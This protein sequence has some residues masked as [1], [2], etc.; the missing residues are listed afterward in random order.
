MNWPGA[1]NDPFYM[2]N[3][4]EN[5]ARQSYY[6]ITD[7]FNM[8]CDGIL[9][10]SGSSY[11]SYFN[12]RTNVVSP[13]DIQMD[14]TVGSQI[15]VTAE[16][17]AESNYTGTNLMFRASLNSVEYTIPGSGWTYTHCMDAMLDLQPSSSGQLFSINPG[18]TVTLNVSFPIPTY[19]PTGLDNLQV[20]GF[21][22]QDSNR[23]VLQARQAGIPLDFPSL[24]LTNY[25]LSDPAPGGNNNGFMEPGETFE[26]WVELSNGEVFAN[27]QNVSAVISTDDPDITVIDGEADFPDILS[28]ASEN[29]SDNPF[30]IEIGENL[31]PHVVTFQIDITA[32][33][34]YTNTEFFQYM[35]GIPEYLIVDDDGGN[36]YEDAYLSYFDDMDLVYNYCNVNEQGP[37]TGATIT[38]YDKVI[39]FT[40]ASATTLD[41][42]EQM[43]LELYLDGGGKLFL[44]SQNLGDEIGG[45]EF[46]TNYM[47]AQADLNYLQV[48]SLDGVPGDPI[49][50]G[51]LILLVGGAFTPTS[52]SSIIPDT[53]AF[54]IYKYTDEDQ[55]CGA[56][57]Y[58]DGYVLVYMAFPWESISPIASGFTH[59]ADVMTSVLAWMDNPLSV[60]PG[61]TVS[62]N[63]P[64]SFEITS[65]SPNPF[66]PETSIRLSVPVSGNIDMVVFNLLGEK[67]A[68]IHE[69]YVSAGNHDF[70]FNGGNL[71]S[72]IYLLKVNTSEGV[73]TEKLVLMK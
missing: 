2:N 69:G 49:T 53:E 20:V 43:V 29:N 44:S 73:L 23:E 36:T 28:G 8:K 16:I 65:I 6:G 34:N 72:G 25:D 11:Q 30:I 38:H 24:T 66:N 42:F 21:V 15:E 63:V 12:Q 33:G 50:E 18:E 1:G 9:G 59:R 52:Q 3:P 41:A 55:S 13:V 67:V 57:R 47:H 46:Y 51:N 5:T 58:T 26:T 56:L 48:L 40:S 45:T 60:D 64:S 35:M 22:Q 17:T 10:N 37:P 14:I 71:S 27:A 68:L 70:T 19:P 4:T 7:V 39:W 31:L 54:P 61:S 62:K 32:D